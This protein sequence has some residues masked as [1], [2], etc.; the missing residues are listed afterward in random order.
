[1]SMDTEWAE[2]T[3]LESRLSFLVPACRANGGRIA[4]RHGTGNQF[5]LALYVGMLTE[6]DGLLH[7][8]AVGAY[9]CLHQ[10]N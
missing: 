2:Q 5:P 1:M 6:E 8:L 10:G 4:G 9:G 3:H 7:R